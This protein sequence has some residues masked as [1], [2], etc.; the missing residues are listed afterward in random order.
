MPSISDG[1]SLSPKMTN[2]AEF[3][4]AAKQAKDSPDL[5]IQQFET[6]GV[7]CVRGLLDP[8]AEL[9]RFKQ[10]LKKAIQERILSLGRDFPSGDID[11]LFNYLCSLNRCYG[12]EIYDVA[13]E[14][15]GFLDLVHHAEFEAISR[16]LLGTNQLH[17]PF[18]KAMFRIDRPHESWNDFHWH[19]DYS[20]NLMSRPTITVWAPL[21]DISPN[22]GMLRI[23]PGSHTRHYPVYLDDKPAL[24][25]VSKSKAAFIHKLS[26]ED[27]DGQSVPMPVSAGDV[28]FFHELMLHRS[29]RNT[30]DKSRWVYTGRYGKLFDPDLIERGWKIERS[31]DFSMLTRIEKGAVV[32]P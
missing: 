8:N 6:H 23:I 3:T 13:R 20:Y 9:D 4:I 17:I 10:T 5:V 22:M 16:T 7:L 30:S 32:E 2:P 25:G 12:S 11:E 27:L 26:H 24:N 1:A 29:G 15:D 19:Q 18:D 21:T 31:A 14:I 28:L